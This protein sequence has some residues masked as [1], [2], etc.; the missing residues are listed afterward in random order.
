MNTALLDAMPQRP[1]GK[2]PFPPAPPS[3]VRGGRR[4]GQPAQ[5]QSGARAGDGIGRPADGAD[6]PA[7]GQ[8]EPVTL[9]RMAGDV[10]MVLAWGALIPGLMWLGHAAGF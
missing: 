9:G 4:A 8:G 3:A 1:P 10:L 7:Q 6:R 5:G 2:W